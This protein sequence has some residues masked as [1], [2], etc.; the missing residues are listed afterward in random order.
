MQKRSKNKIISILTV[1]IMLFSTCF[2][3]ASCGGDSAE[4]VTLKFNIQIYDDKGEIICNLT[5]TTVTGTDITISDATKAAG[6]VI[7]LEVV[8]DSDKTVS[9]IGNLTSL[10]TVVP[11]T[12]EEEETDETDET[13]ATEATE[14]EEETTEAQLYYWEVWV[15]GSADPVSPKQLLQEGDSIVWKWV[16]WVDPDAEA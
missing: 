15:N 10:D 9:K 14:A 11:T 2:I 16:L 12:D 6:E 13:E 3:L 1:L 5:D 7:E 4:D 8:L